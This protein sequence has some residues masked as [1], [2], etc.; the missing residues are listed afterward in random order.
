VLL[1]H[2]YGGS[3]VALEPLADLFA[4]AGYEVAAMSMRGFGGSTGVDDLGLHQPQDVAAVAAWFRHLSQLTRLYAVGVSQGG[5]VVLLAAAAG[6]PLDGIAAWA[7]V[8]DVARWRA[9]TAYAGIPEYVDA[10]CADGRYLE[11]SPLHV[12][13]QIRVPVLLVH[14][15]A[16]TRVPTEQS[17]SL[18][19]ALLAAGCPSKLELLAGVAH[20]QRDQTGH[21]NSF[22]LSVDFFD[23]LAP[24]A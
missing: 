20:R 23:S 24:D 10:M 7:A 8:T 4:E 21:P 13:D 18:H 22:D 5:Q 11:R 2:G 14:G 16:D 6:A 17:V 9:T 12:A 19:R 3:A 15:D 1:V